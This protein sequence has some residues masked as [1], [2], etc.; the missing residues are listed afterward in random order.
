MLLAQSATKYTV[1][2]AEGKVRVGPGLDQIRILMYMTPVEVRM[3]SFEFATATRIIFGAGSVAQ[4]A[5]AARQ[6][7]HG[8]F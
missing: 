2:A 3:I 5:P 6:M 7:G 8:P 1:D 4:V